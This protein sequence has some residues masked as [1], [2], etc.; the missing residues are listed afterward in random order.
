M[1]HSKHFFCFL[2]L[3][4]SE[5]NSGLIIFR[6]QTCLWW[7]RIH[8]S[9]RSPFLKL[10]IMYIVRWGYQPFQSI[11]VCWS[12]YPIYGEWFKPATTLRFNFYASFE[13]FESALPSLC[14]ASCWSGKTS[15]KSVLAPS[16]G[17]SQAK[18]SEVVFSLAITASSLTWSSAVVGLSKWLTYLHWGTAYHHLAKLVDFLCTN[19]LK[20]PDKTF[21]MRQSFISLLSHQ[22]WIFF[23]NLY[24]AQPACLLLFAAFVAKRR[25]NRGW[26]PSKFPPLKLTFWSK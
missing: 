22:R 13:H 23:S 7:H 18:K 12:L 16:N 4:F 24:A 14:Q 1:L 10:L 2:C 6:T 5:K 8:F 9:K 15:K 19:V 26:L 25:D 20:S 3:F 21:R 17:E 11:E